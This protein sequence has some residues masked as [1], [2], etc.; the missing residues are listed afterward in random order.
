MQISGAVVGHLTTRLLQ[1]FAV[2]IPKSAVSILH[3]VQNSTADIVTKID[4]REHATPVL[5]ELHWFPVKRI[6]YK[7]LL[8]T[9]K[10]LNSLAPEYLCNMVE[11]CAGQNILVLRRKHSQYGMRTFAKL[12]LC[13]IL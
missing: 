10:A 12:L 4:P 5:K 6:E 2:L 11:S 7:M 9:Y 8:Y 1:W 3:S 13:G